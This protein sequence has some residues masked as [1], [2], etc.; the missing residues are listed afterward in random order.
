MIEDHAADDPVMDRASTSM[1]EIALR[2]H[3]GLQSSSASLS[4]ISSGTY[5]GTSSPNLGALV[6]RTN[7]T[8]YRPHA[9]VHRSVAS[10]F[11]SVSLYMT[12]SHKR[13]SARPRVEGQGRWDR[14]SWTSQND[15]AAL[16]HKHNGMQIACASRR[17]ARACH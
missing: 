7:D 5:K 11:H 17:H 9:S 10:D 15:H 16:S 3:D 1:M 12:L 8:C 13:V 2:A 6:D 4:R 14:S